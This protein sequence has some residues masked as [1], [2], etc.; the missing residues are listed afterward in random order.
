MDPNAALAKIHSILRAHAGDDVLTLTT[1]ETETLFNHIEA[2][3]GWLSRGG[4][5]PQ[6]WAR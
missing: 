2:L 4:F 5:L 3:D 6:A 1:E